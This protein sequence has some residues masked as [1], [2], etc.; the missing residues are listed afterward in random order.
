MGRSRLSWAGSAVAPWGIALG[1][2]VSITAQAG[3]DPGWTG[4][5]AAPGAGAGRL[6]PVREA[7]LASKFGPPALF[8]AQGGAESPIVKARWSLGA[9]ED[10]AAVPDEIEPN[11]AV[12][13][14]QR[15][16]PAIDRTRKGDPLVV[17]RPGFDA[18]L[19]RPVAA[20]EDG[21]ANGR[22]DSPSPT[23]VAPVAEFAASRPQRQFDDG[24]TPSVPLEMALNSSTPTPSDGEAIV[25][26]RPPAQTTAAA[27]SDANGK[28][29]YAA[30]IDPKD[31]ARQMRCLSEAI[32]FEAR[33]EPEQGQAAVAQVVL[34][35]VRSGIFPSN[36][37]AVVYQDRN[38]PFACQFSFA[39]DGSSLRIE[40]PS[41]WATATQIAEQVVSGANYNPKVAE[42]L[43]YHANYVYPDWA[44]ELRRVDR[45]GT[46]IFYAMRG[47]VNWAPSARGDA[48]AATMA[49]TQTMAAR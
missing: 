19:R 46:H 13:Q 8:A 11:A 30:L 10:L 29:N 2:L 22:A 26:A 15:N 21:A 38:H 4:G 3:Q 5:L 12:K 34:N 33:G 48:P 28:P 1:F 39:C 37:C 9:P 32:Y 27:Q 41:A 23:A 24:A 40:E 47:G 7:L 17:L 6:S 45:I 31:S 16:F 44:G 20:D 42:A 35:R 49:A 14:G 43:N 18:R 25:A 36:V